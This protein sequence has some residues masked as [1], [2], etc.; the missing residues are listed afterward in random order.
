MDS[1]TT[2]DIDLILK[3]SKGDQK[4]YRYIYTSYYNNLCIYLC[5]YTNNDQL[6][7]D[8]AQDVLLNIWEKR[9][10]LNIHTS[11]KSYLYK[12]AYNAFINKYRANK[13]TEE[14]LEEIKFTSLQQL[15]NREEDVK[16]MEQRLSY[17]KLA[18]DEL[19]P[20]CKKA[21]LLSKME[22]YKYQEI[23]KTMNI[24]VKT[25]ENH[26]SKAFKLLR[27]KMSSNKFLLLFINFFNSKRS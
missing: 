3:L 19:P 12:S 23:A 1:N 9:K 6:A 8:I 14:K 5:S 18:I 7:E 2:N 13:R 11:L 22:G 20:K 21:L 4:A 17:L 10:K 15:E 16:M 24:S 27:K 26:I 25:V